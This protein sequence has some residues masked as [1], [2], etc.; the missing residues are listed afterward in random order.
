MFGER[1][2][3][4]SVV[5]IAVSAV[6]VAL[7]VRAPKGLSAARRGTSASCDSDEQDSSVQPSASHAASAGNA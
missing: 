7:V 6:G 2:T 3:P 5:G 4:V 1:L